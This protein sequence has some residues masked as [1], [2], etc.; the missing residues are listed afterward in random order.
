MYPAELYDS[1]FRAADSYKKCV[2][3]SVKKNA[4]KCL[5][6]EEVREHLHVFER[7]TPN[8]L[9]NQITVIDSQFSDMMKA[10]DELQ[11]KKEQLQNE[12]TATFELADTQSEGVIITMFK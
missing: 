6:A 7:H 2:H 10:L 3:E 11:R 4:R 9:K 5:H 1:V 8:E 12:R